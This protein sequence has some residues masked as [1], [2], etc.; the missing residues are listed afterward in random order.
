MGESRR[1]GFV[2]TTGYSDPTKQKSRPNSVM[3]RPRLRTRPLG[4]QTPSDF[5]NAAPEAEVLELDEIR[6]RRLVRREYANG[7]LRGYSLAEVSDPTPVV[8]EQ[9]AA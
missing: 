5:S 9:R 7:I 6:R 8:P 1:D 4:G 3:N 2:D